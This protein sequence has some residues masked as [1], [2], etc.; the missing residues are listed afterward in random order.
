MQSRNEACCSAELAIP[1]ILLLGAIVGAINGLIHVHLR[2]PSFMSSL[3]MGF[4]GTGAAILMTGG[5]IVKI[6]DETFRALLTERV[7]GF[8]LM[9]YG[10]LFFLILGYLVLSHTRVGRNFYA[11]GGGED[12]AGILD[13]D[14][15][16]DRRM[17][18]KQCAFQM[19]KA[20]GL[21][22]TLHCLDEAA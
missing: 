13:A 11:V 1:A 14:N 3:A 9:V 2:I 22:L 17:H 12:L 7:F 18:D 10:A 16:I 19:G 4:V 6:N 15:R 5:N 21:V 20:V 8:P